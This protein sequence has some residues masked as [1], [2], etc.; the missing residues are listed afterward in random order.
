[1]LWDLDPES[2]PFCYDPPFTVVTRHCECPVRAVS[3]HSAEVGE[4]VHKRWLARELLPERVAEVV[5]GI[6]GDD[7][8]AAAHCCHL[9]RKAA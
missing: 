4:A 7:E 3:H 1:M 5:C 9:D 2:I 6:R 8:H